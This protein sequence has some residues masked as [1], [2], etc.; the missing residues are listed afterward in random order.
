MAAKVNTKMADVERKQEN[1]EVIDVRT[2]EEVEEG[3]IPSAIHIPLDQV[4]DQMN[5]LDKEKEYI[6]V[7]GSG[8]RADKAADMLN[9]HGI[10]AKTMEGGMKEWDGEVR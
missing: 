6:T 10:K 1:V 4:E 9:D 8:K 3:I 2:D 5:Q 7:C